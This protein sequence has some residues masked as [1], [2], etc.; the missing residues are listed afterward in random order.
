[1]KATRRTVSEPLRIPL[2]PP[3]QNLGLEGLDD[4]QVITIT[5]QARGGICATVQKIEASR[6]D[7]LQ[8]LKEA[9]KYLQ[10]STRADDIPDILQE[11]HPLELPLD[12]DTIWSHCE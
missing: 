4:E 10:R 9:H 12:G 2:L 7:P 8:F 11:K 5:L 3:C 1:M 6:K